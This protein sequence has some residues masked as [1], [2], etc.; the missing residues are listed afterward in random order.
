MK[1]RF[2]NEARAK[3]TRA[4]FGQADKRARALARIIEEIRA[5][6]V[7]ALSLTQAFAAALAL[8]G[9][10]GRCHRF[11]APMSVTVS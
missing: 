2:T 11:L 3:A 6:G 1:G 7:L 9:T 8:I 10:G 5:T 4:G